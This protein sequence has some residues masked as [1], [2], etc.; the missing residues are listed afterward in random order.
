MSTNDVT[1]IWLAYRAEIW[2][3]VIRAGLPDADDVK[4]GW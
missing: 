3:D 2:L 4:I 1:L